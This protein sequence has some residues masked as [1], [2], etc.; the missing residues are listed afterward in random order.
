MIVAERTGVRIVG[1][2]SASRGSRSVRRGSAEFN[3]SNGYV[4]RA[5]TTHEQGNVS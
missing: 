5:M 3:R 4:C 2:E 1:C